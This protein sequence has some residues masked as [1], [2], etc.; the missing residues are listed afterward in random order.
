MWVYT[1]PAAVGAVLT[2][3]AFWWKRPTTPPSPS[4]EQESYSFFRG[5]TKVKK[6]C[7][8]PLFLI[9][10]CIQT[11]HKNHYLLFI[12]FLHWWS[13]AYPQSTNVLHT[14]PIQRI[15]IAMCLCIHVS[16]IWA[17]SIAHIHC[18]KNRVVLTELGYL[19]CN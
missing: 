15:Y 11:Q 16:H 1:I 6:I 4:A 13:S 3:F 17:C 9:L 8:R 5:V 19:S 18:K 7:P 10:Y 2:V 12:N 14:I